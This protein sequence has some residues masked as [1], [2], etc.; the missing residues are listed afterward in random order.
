MSERALDGLRAEF[1]RLAP[2]DWPA[3]LRSVEARRIVR[4][5]LL[6]LDRPPAS[7]SRLGSELRLR[8]RQSLDLEVV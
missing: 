1:E 6:A 8:V 3:V 7:Y 5:L 2:D 4:E